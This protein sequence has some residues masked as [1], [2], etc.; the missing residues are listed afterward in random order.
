MPGID[1]TPL[2]FNVFT[3]PEKA[4]VGERPQPFGPPLSWDPI[5]AT[6]IY[7]QYDAVLIDALTTAAEASTLADWIALHHRNLT[8]IYITHGHFDHFYG[9]SVLLDRFPAAKAIAIPESVELM[10]QQLA[11]DWLRR[12]NQLFPGL[13]PTKLLAAQ[14]FSGDTFTLE[15]HDL[16][17]IRQGRTDTVH[18]T[19]LHVPALDL[20]VGG[21]VVYNRCHMFVGDTTPESR[22][23]WIAA[24][25]RLA[26]LNPTNVIAGHK[27]P[28]VPDS[29]DALTMS[30]SYLTDFSRLIETGKPQKDIYDEMTALYPDWVSHQSWLMFNFPKLTVE[31]A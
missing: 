24:L 3:A 8:T 22:A 15:G 29:P 12:A 28:G 17:I 20:V 19:S 13:L 31:D 4:V 1:T 25:D 14:P 16:H 5:T 23:N 21:D 30:K 11:R 2:N 9:L 27:K 18:T 7:G 10:Q 6:L 26:A